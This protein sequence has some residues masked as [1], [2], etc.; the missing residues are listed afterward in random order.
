MDALGLDIRNQTANHITDYHGQ[1]FD[2]VITVCDQ[3]REVCPTFEAGTLQ[4]HWGYPDPNLPSD[5]AQRRDAYQ[6]VT[7]QLQARIRYFVDE[8]LHTNPHP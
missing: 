1:R 6:Q 5:P 7:A 4:Y 8:V 3:V 2:Y